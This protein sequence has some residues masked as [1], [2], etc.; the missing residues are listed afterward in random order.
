MSFSSDFI[1]GFPGE[2]KE[3]FEGTMNIINEVRFDE[4]LVL[5]IVPDQTL[6]HQICR[7]MSLKKKKKK[8]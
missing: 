3:D 4:S 6:L 1:V 7:M 8:D 5:F 2:T